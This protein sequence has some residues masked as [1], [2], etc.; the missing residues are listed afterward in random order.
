MSAA[1]SWVDT[2]VKWYNT[3]HLHSQIRFVTP[4]DR[5]YGREESI[6]NRRR[7]VYTEARQKNPDRWSGQT[8]NWQ[9]VAVVRLN[10]EKN[11]TP[12]EVPLKKVA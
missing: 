7:E 4:D 10:P 1:Q 9:S 2:F 5:H 11:E 3:D 6:L 12:E 8:R